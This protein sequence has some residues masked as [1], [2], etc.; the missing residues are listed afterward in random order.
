MFVDE[1]HVPAVGATL[2]KMTP[3]TAGFVV[4][5]ARIEKDWPRISTIAPRPTAALLG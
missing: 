2:L 1:Q 4:T 3:C 5:S